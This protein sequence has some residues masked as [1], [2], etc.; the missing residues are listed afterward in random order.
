MR[1]K[2]VFLLVPALICAIAGA[3]G[4]ATVTAVRVDEPPRIDGRL[5]D[6]AWQKAAVID[7]FVQREPHPGAPV[8]QKTQV[9]VCYTADFIFF[10]FR[11]YDDPSRITA[12]EMARDVDL[13]PDDRV[14]II[15]DTFLDGRNAYWF[16]IGPRGSI[17]DALVSENGA[18][19]NKQWDGL[20]AGKARIH[21]DGWDAE[22]AIPF[23][24]LSFRPGQT[25]WG[26]KLIRHIKRNLER[27]YWPTRQSGHVRIPGLRQRHPGR[28]SRELPRASVWTSR[29]VR[30]GGNGPEHRSRASRS[31]RCR[32]GRLLPVDARTQDRADRQYRFCPDRGRRPPDQ[33]HAIPALLPREARLL[34]GRRQLLLVRSGRAR[35]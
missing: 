30:P 20:W 21:A 5:D 6:A 24:T 28:A 17:G 18:A 29:P 34:P 16:Q 27:A 15:L 33:S 4:Q 22:I 35:V 14:Q 7:G 10:A 25:R 26:L 3:F 11:C 19:F 8:S 9:L 31:R 32:S 23:R 12:K 13:S 2:S 1:L